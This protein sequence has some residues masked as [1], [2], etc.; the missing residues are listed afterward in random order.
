MIYS[1][2]LRTTP[3][4]DLRGALQRGLKNIIVSLFVHIVIQWSQASTVTVSNIKLINNDIIEGAYRTSDFRLVEFD[5]GWK[6]SW[7]DDINWDAAWIFIKYRVER[8]EWKHATLNY[9]DGTAKSDGHGTSK[10]AM[11]STPADG[12]GVFIYRKEI[13]KEMQPLT[14]EKVTLRWN[15]GRDGV[16]RSENV[17]VRVFG[18]EMVYVPEGAF[19]AGSGGS[20][21]KAFNLATIN[22]SDATATPTGKDGILG[23]PKGGYPAGQVP[24]EKSAWPN[25][26]SAFYCMKYEVSQGQYANFLNTLT[27]EQAKNRH[28]NR[29]S[30]RYTIRESNDVFFSSV[31][32]RGC[33][34]LSWMDG[35]AWA[36]WAAL[37]PMTEL[38]YEKAC[39]GTALPVVNEYAWGSTEIHKSPYKLINE[40]TI[41]EDIEAIDTMNGNAAYNETNG[42]KGPYRCGIFLSNLSIYDRGRS[43]ASFYRIMELSG[44]LWER[45]ISVSHPQGR[46]FVDN[47]GDGRLTPGTGDA[48]VSSW[49]GSNAEGAGFRGGGWRS[50]A[51]VLRVSDRVGADDVRD[52]RSSALGFRAVRN[53]R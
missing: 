51:S 1:R 53:A 32:N 31:P 19:T 22:T 34:F 15:S 36:D 38:E 11:L 3:R 14:F 8:D 18:I 48:D 27:T 2:T 7:R 25:G 5:V 49:P 52:G 12:K 30:A 24:P 45:V 35:A 47:H 20:E 21:F 44:N 13:Q 39:R 23:S 41:S 4:Y 16:A 50:G 9:V 43:G 6:H 28:V 26:F 10:G 46:K 40:D 33:N 37:R 29:R 17:D 42:Y